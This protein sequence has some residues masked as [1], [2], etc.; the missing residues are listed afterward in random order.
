[1]PVSTF[2]AMAPPSVT[3][4][5]LSPTLRGSP[6][7]FLGGG[8]SP[9][10]P[11]RDL[12]VV[13]GDRAA[14]ADGKARTT[15]YRDRKGQGHG[16]SRLRHRVLLL[17]SQALNRLPAVSLPP[18][19]QDIFRTPRWG[20]CAS[21]SI[22]P[23]EP[24]TCSWRA[25]RSGPRPGSRKQPPPVL[26]LL[27]QVGRDCHHLFFTLPRARHRYQQP[28]TT[29]VRPSTFPFPRQADPSGPGTRG[30]LS[31]EAGCRGRHWPSAA[32]SARG[33]RDGSQ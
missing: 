23:K 18:V 6:F 7:L 14:R 13:H 26:A 8:R 33:P 17:R 12:S 24:S 9:T 32:D 15:S 16:L 4:T 1:M 27:A 2:R 19:S 30:G 5:R 21:R 22:G 10:T 3:S 31:N 29:R 20:I 11:V 25:P 28:A